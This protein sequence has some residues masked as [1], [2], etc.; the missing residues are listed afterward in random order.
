MIVMPEQARCL[1]TSE[2]AKQLGVSQSTLNKWRLSGDGP[3]YLKLGRRVVYRPADVESFIAGRIRAS[4]VA[5]V[6]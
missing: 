6:A 2:V 3:R 5:K 4:T 1:Q